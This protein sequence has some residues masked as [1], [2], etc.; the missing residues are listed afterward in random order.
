MG[1]TFD[2]QMGRRVAYLDSAGVPPR[3]EREFWTY[4]TFLVDGEQGEW[5][6]RISVSPRR[7]SQSVSGATSDT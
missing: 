3:H 4:G 2:V 7:V 6:G 1:I 5:D